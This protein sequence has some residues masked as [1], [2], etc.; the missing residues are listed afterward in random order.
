VRDCFLRAI[1]PRVNVISRSRWGRPLTKGG[2]TAGARPP[3]AL[4]CPWGP[5]RHALVTLCEWARAQARP[6]AKRRHQDASPGCVARAE[7]FQVRLVRAN[8]A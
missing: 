6:G 5:E 1:G 3:P 7:T 8:G 4:A 2:L